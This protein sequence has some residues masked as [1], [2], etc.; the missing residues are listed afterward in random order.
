MS[1]INILVATDVQVDFRDGALGTKEAQ[2]SI[3]AIVEKIE[4]AKQAGSRVFLTKDSHGCDYLET[5]EGRHL[6]VIHTV[7]DTHGWEF[8]PEIKKALEGYLVA[9]VEKDRFGSF[10]LVNKIREYI[11]T[12]GGDYE[13]GRGLKI[14]VIGWCTDICVISNALLLKA[15][16]PEAEIIVDSKCC[17]GV[18]PEL[19]DA[20]LKVMASCQIEII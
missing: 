10:D 5:S 4:E 6:P 20:A 8:I 13:S 7:K 2:D 14:T 9:V 11:K 17:A 3:P 16:F 1:K 18:T 19:H 15:A 12:A